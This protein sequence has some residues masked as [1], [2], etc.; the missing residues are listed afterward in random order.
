MADCRAPGDPAL[1]GVRTRTAKP[2]AE[3]RRPSAFWPLGAILVPFMRAVSDIRIVHPERLP[4]T[5]AYILTPNH[6]SNIDPVVVAVAVWRLGRAPRFLA[7]A[8]LFRIPVV[9][10]LFRAA[11]QIPVQRGG[12]RAGVPLDAARRLIE[13]G[14][15]VIVYPE[16]SLTRDPDL[17]PMRGRSGA[18]RLAL[19]LGL[20]VIPCAQWGSQALMPVNTTKLVL[21]GR[22]RIDVRFGEPVDLRDLANDRA[23]IA[24]A[25]DRIMAAITALLEEVRGERAPVE[26]WNPAAHGQ[27]ETGTF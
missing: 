7:K 11:G 24:A 15:G 26:R 6:L 25:T 21:K 5:G 16:G 19:D 3:K 9:G 14:Q 23:G 22:P 27:T 20:P 4:A 18:A 10:T 12:T 1:A 2:R 8:S 17:W 13:E